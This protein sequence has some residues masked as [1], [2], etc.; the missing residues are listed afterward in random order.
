[1]THTLV[2]LGR[3]QRNTAG[4]RGGGFKRASEAGGPP[5]VGALAL[6]V[7]ALLACK[8]EEPAPATPAVNMKATGKLAGD[9][10]IESATNPG[11]GSYS[12]DVAIKQSGETYRVDWKQPG[13]AQFG[14]GIE[15]GT[16][17]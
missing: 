1:M 2:G 16:A 3:S 5:M 17:L 13:G 11:G 7:L 10:S 12:G 6:I 15:S 14:V 9:Y 8:K 4:A